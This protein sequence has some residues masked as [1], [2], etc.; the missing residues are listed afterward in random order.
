MILPTSYILSDPFPETSGRPVASGGFGDIYEGTLNGSK[1]R[2]KSLRVYS[3][4][5]LQKTYKVAF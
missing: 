3:G 4:S 5:D 1:V 2:I